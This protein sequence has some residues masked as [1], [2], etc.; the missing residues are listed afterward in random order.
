MNAAPLQDLSR[1]DS[2]TSTATSIAFVQSESSF[3]SSDLHISD[4]VSALRRR[5]HSSIAPAVATATS[6]PNTPDL[7]PQQTR[8]LP[9]PR[10][11]ASPGLTDNHSSSTSTSSSLPVVTGSQ[12]PVTPAVGLSSHLPGKFAVDLSTAADIG[13]AASGSIPA[14]WPSPH[15]HQL[16]EAVSDASDTGRYGSPVIPVIP[17]AAV[18]T[19]ALLSGSSSSESDVLDDLQSDIQTAPAAANFVTNDVY[20]HLSAQSLATADATGTDDVSMHHWQAN[21]IFD[22]QASLWD[23]LVDGTAVRAPTEQHDPVLESR[24]S[25]TDLPEVR[26]DCGTQQCEGVSGTNHVEHGSSCS[27]HDEDQH[28]RQVFSDLFDTQLS[29]FLTTQ[30]EALSVSAELQASAALDA[31][32]VHSQAT[33]LSSTPFVE[34]TT[35]PGLT[36]SATINTTWVE[37]ASMPNGGYCH[38]QAGSTASSK[39]TAAAT[40][41]AAADAPTKASHVGSVAT[42][43]EPE[44]HDGDVSKGEPVTTAVSTAQLEIMGWD[45][46]A[47]TLGNFRLLS[48]SGSD[49]ESA[50]NLLP[51]PAELSPLTP[52]AG[53]HEP[54]MTQHRVSDD[55]PFL[56]AGHSPAS[57]EICRSQDLAHFDFPEVGGQMIQ[58]GF[59][60]VEYMD[61]SPVSP[62]EWEYRAMMLDDH[63]LSE[64]YPGMLSDADECDAHGV[65]CLGDSRS[66]A[67]RFEQCMSCYP[68]ATCAC[69]PSAALRPGRHH[70]KSVF[71]RLWATIR[72]KGSA[73]VHPSFSHERYS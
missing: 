17:P 45:M 3:S 25:L 22:S 56:G 50:T 18:S 29:Q 32:S 21:S 52:E 60:A 2:S 27:M 64:R 33:E 69:C 26:S 36:S 11:I 72:A 19:D 4:T 53:L 57:P 16:H 1:T 30:E 14:Q 37:D 31:A 28:Q 58:Q 71:R 48:A 63:F 34:F 6:Q 39:A 49:A 73:C 59:C 47:D 23:T 40:S 24:Q 10:L 66:C 35:T 51:E 7:S 5:L 67:V 8:L 54:R 65:G 9:T 43:H 41:T 42:K 13:S 55:S 15:E 20:Q 62:L 12:A 70:K 68:C 46:F 44:P 61:S 38:S